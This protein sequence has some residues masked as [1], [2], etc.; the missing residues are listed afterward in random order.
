[1]DDARLPDGRVI[2][3]WSDAARLRV[4][5]L[6]YPGL[7]RR[8]TAIDAPRPAAPLLTLRLRRPVE[9]VIAGHAPSMAPRRCGGRPR[10]DHP[11]GA[12]A[13]PRSHGGSPEPRPVDR[14]ARDAV[15][16]V[17]AVAVRRCGDR[18]RRLR[19]GRTAN[20]GV[21]PRD[22]CCARGTRRSGCWRPTQTP[23]PAPDRRLSLLVELGVVDGH[24]RPVGE[25]G[26]E[27][28]A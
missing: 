19:R 24:G 22:G 15:R 12:A 1:M 7:S 4:E 14:T 18:S 26:N 9:D 2:S 20:G 8:I 3:W 10:I 23:T 17:G 6:A 25:L 16:A 21:V 27:C 11:D 5:L 13:V 28:R